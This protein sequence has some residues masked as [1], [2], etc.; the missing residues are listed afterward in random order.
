MIGRVAGQDEFCQSVR[1]LQIRGTILG[2]PIIRTG[3]CWDPLI[4][5]N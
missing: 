5:G 4:L 1:I 2:V 3:P